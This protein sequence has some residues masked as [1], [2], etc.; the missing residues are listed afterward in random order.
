MI[1]A[2]YCGDCNHRLW[3]HGDRAVGGVCAFGKYPDVCDCPGWLETDALRSI[4][5]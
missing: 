5:R 1:L 2:R 4:S 3:W